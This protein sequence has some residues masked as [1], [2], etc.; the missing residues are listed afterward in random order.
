MAVGPSKTKLEWGNLENFGDILHEIRSS[1]IPGFRGPA[2]R[3]LDIWY[4]TA[5]H[6][7][8]N[9]MLANAVA[10]RAYRWACSTKKR[11][12]DANFERCP[13]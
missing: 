10:A 1:K 7:A 2:T 9:V 13:Y 8:R 6:G 11:V 5:R 12:Y 3:R 4:E